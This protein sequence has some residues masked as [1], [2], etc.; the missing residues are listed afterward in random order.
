M[1]R[2]ALA[3]NRSI[4]EI[5]AAH[6][7]GAGELLAFT[8]A[9]LAEKADLGPSKVRAGVDGRV[10][11]LRDRRGVPHIAAESTH[12][13]Y[14]GLGYA[15]AQDRLW[16]LDYLR[17]QA[18]GTLSEVFG[19]SALESDI[20][21]RTLNLADFADKIVAQLSTTAKAALAAFAEG[22]NAWLAA[23]PSGLPVEFEVNSYE[24]GPWS[25]VDSIAIQRRWW[26]YLTGRLGVILTPEAVRA[27]VGD[28]PRFDAFFAPDATVA[29]IVHEG[30]Y[31]PFP[32]P[33]DLPKGPL[34][35]QFSGVEEGLGSNNW[36]TAP[37]MNRDGCALLA[38]DP[39]VYFTAPAEWYEFHLHGAGYDAAG[40]SYPG[41]C[42]LLYGRNQHLAWGLTNN[43][44]SLRDLYVETVNPEDANQYLNDGVWTPFVT[45]VDEIAIKGEEPYRHE[46]RY[47]QGRPVGDHL[48]PAGSAAG[49]LLADPKYAG[50][51]LSLRWVGLEFSDEIACLIDLARAGT[52]QEGREALRS[53]R[54]PT[55]SFMM[56]D[57]SGSIAYQCTGAIPIRDSQRR[58]Y[59]HPDDPEDAWLGTIPF[60]GLPHVINP[61]RGWIASANNPT[62]PADYPY[63]LSGVWA[64]EDR[65]ARAEKL[66]QER[67]PHTLE[68]FRTMQ[69][70]VHSGRA[71]HGIAGLLPLIDG[72]GD[73]LVRAAAEI[74]QRW[75]AVMSTDSAAPAIFSVFFWKW[76]QRVIRERFSAALHPLVQ[77]AGWGLSSDLLHAN[78]ADWFE[79]DAF[80]LAAVRESFGDALD[81]LAERF[82]SDPSAW[83]WG[84][85][86]R[87]GAVHPAARTPL[88]HE[89]FDLPPLPH[90]GG[91]G[92]LASAF[93]LPAGTFDTRLGASYRL[94]A[95]L[96][97]DR[98]M[99]CLCWPGQ[100][101]HPGSPHY[102]DQVASF[103]AEQHQPAPYIWRDVEARLEWRTSLSPMA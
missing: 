70:D 31:D 85:L 82:G 26:W 59:R 76:H 3:D 2:A 44:S 16:Q 35:E 12:D 94:L 56:A 103:H 40:C 98:E 68:T 86:H 20:L 6:E 92:T 50:A 13:L 51:V 64:P 27:G 60:D 38:S 49:A 96:G 22:V 80:R 66:L 78:V 10:D 54:V 7:I 37:E 61:G 42:G 74:L 19:R 65:A 89:L 83:R 90:I 87:L 39:H 36:A 9:Y 17:R 4:D 57:D 72:R 14:F 81:W 77:D 97:P 48:M 93:Y 18:R 52:V 41:M 102:A 25:A 47:A 71:E 33:S 67:A 1:A 11:I 28:G 30:E 23:L 34:G 84:D 99:R 75:D 101:G 53:W 15:Q 43:L 91:A 79:A 63:P 55:F 8:R 32:A 24:P 62:A 58:G 73:S 88:Q 100:S 5:G 69:Y 46:T 45:R 21:S 29:Y 95:S